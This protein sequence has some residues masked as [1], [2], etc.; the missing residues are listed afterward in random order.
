VS[1]Q[2]KSGWA[3]RNLTALQVLDFMRQAFLQEM[4]FLQRMA[5]LFE[6]HTRI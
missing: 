4:S 3:M 2:I 6:S 5:W 1:G